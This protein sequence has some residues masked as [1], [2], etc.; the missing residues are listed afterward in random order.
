M[1]GVVGRAARW[2]LRLRVLSVLLLCVLT[3][4]FAVMAGTYRLPGR[5]L[6][7]TILAGV[8]VLALD[9]LLLARR[10]ATAT[11]SE[12]SHHLIHVIERYAPLVV[13]NLMMLN[14]VAPVLGLVAG[15]MDYVSVLK[16]W[17]TL[18]GWLSGWVLFCLFALGIVGLLAVLGMRL[19]D[20][21]ML[22]FGPASRVPLM[23]DRGIVALTAVYCAWAMALTFNGT[24]DGASATEHR[25]EILDVWGV[26]KTP[27]WWADVRSWDAPGGIKRVLIYPERDQMVPALLDVG[28]HVRV[29][30]RPGFF[31]LRWVESMQLDFDHDLEALVAAAPSAASPRKQL[32]AM[33]LRDGRWPEA[34]THAAIYARHHPADRDFMAQVAA[35]LRTPR[36]AEPAT[37]INKV[38]LPVS[39]GRGR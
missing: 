4:R 11:P 36:E 15:A 39:Q 10:V 26:P 37:E 9:A 13:L 35:I 28:Q 27:L 2:L 30:I 21:I 33:L 20:R 7:L 25:S 3:Y 14:V 31:G 24:F 16:A 23:V 5:L 19:A 32:I 22:R 18:L 12:T 8:V 34:A 29:R 6:A 1:S 17:L 38:T